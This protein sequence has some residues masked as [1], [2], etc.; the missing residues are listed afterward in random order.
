MIHRMSASET[1]PQ[2]PLPGAQ[3]EFVVPDC[4]AYLNGNSL[5]VMP[6]RAQ[7]AVAAALETWGADAVAGWNTANW[8][9]LTQQAGDKIGRII[10]A[11][12]GEVTV[13]DSTSVNLYKLLHAALA[14]R[15]ERNTLLCEAG[16]F[17]TDL[18]VMQG[19]AAARPGLKLRTVEPSGVIDALRDN[20]A[21]LSLSHVN[22]RDGKRFDMAAVTKAAHDA[23]ALV[24]WDLAHSAGAVPLDLAKDQVDFAVGC[25]YKFLNGG[26]GAPAFAYAAQRHH[27]AL[28]NPIAGWFGH[29]APFVFAPNFEPAPGVARLQVGTPPVLS[30]VALDAALD[31]VLQADEVALFAK[32]QTM[33]ERAHTLIAERLT[34]RGFACISPDPDE[35]H[36][37]Q[38]SLRHPQAWPLI[39]ALAA[40]GVV[41]DFRAPD[42]LR[43]GFTPLY[44]PSEAVDILVETLVRLID[45]GAWDQPQFHAQQRVT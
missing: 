16:N 17:P 6:K 36:G 32:A 30:L 8:V 13:A 27:A 44:T 31:V 43:F 26:P 34:P 25:G 35:N 12:A 28:Q 21:V 4:A 37:S 11:K 20:V 33:Y 40:E 45:T 22:Y 9:G 5:G 38:I 15:P 29:K 42:V 39:R 10:G 14:L 19:L 7:R 3:D 24:V 23:G 2:S 18:Y 1:S 41:G